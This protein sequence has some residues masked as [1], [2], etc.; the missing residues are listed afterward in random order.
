MDKKLYV[1]MSPHIHGDDSVAR[2]M[3]RVILALVPALLV[4]VY[5]FGWPALL[6]TAISIASCVVFEYLITR[7]LM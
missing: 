3:Y 6:V 7:Y 1:S 5:A 4:S 2:N